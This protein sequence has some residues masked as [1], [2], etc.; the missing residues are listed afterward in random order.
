M[1]VEEGRKSAFLLSDSFLV[2]FV[3]V[4]AFIFVFLLFS[5]SHSL[6]PSSSSKGLCFSVSH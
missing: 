1:T 6:D 5:P 3:F 2:V 4:V